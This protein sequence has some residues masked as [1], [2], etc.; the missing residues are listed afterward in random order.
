MR[1][2]IF[3]AFI[4]ILSPL[5]PEFYIYLK[6]QRYLLVWQLPSALCN[7]FLPFLEPPPHLLPH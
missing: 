7:L 5:I 2:R 6:G 3:Q 1:I 4:P